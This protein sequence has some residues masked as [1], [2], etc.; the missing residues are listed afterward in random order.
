MNIHM[1]EVWS[2]SRWYT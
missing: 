1:Y 2:V